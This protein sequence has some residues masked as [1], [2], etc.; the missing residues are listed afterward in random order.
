MFVVLIFWFWI[1]SRC[2]CWCMILCWISSVV[3][4]KS[5][6]RLIFCLRFCCWCVFVLMCLIRIGVL[7]WCFVLFFWKCLCWKIWCVC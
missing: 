6:L 7:V 3:I 5:F 2:M 1:I 4:L